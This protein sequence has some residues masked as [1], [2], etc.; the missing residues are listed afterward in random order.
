MELSVQ[1]ELFLRQSLTTRAILSPKLLIK[2]RK[3]INI[4]TQGGNPC[5]GLYREV[6]QDQIP[7][8]QANAMQRK[9]ELLTCLYR[10]GIQHKGKT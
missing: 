3:K 6:L 9:I 5:D 10:P 7:W 1:E 2:D 4:P 8:D